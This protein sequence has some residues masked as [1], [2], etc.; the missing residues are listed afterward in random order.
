MEAERPFSLEERLDR[1]EAHKHDP[2]VNQSGVDPGV[3][4]F[5]AAMSAFSYHRLRDEAESFRDP[6]IH[7][8]TLT[9]DL[10]VALSGVMGPHHHNV[11]VHKVMQ[12]TQGGPVR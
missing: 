3:I 2:T 4:L 8:S 11:E 12:A 1:T 9:V 7:Y 10:A 6:R 5:N